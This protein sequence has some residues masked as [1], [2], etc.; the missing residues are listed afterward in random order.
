MVF[1]D[2]LFLGQNIFHFLVILVYFCVVFILEVIK[3][4]NAVVLDHLNVL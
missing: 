3:F 2:N 4:D 1:E